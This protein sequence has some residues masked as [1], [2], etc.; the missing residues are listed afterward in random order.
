MRRSNSWPISIHGSA[1]SSTVN[2]TPSPE[3]PPRHLSPLSRKRANMK[4]EAKLFFFQADDGIR[5]ADVT[6]VQTC[7]LPICH[8][9]LD[10][11][12]LGR[13]S[14][15]AGAGRAAAGAILVGLGVP[16]GRAGDGADTGGRAEAA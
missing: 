11:Q 14:D 16:A 9:R 1:S 6:G 3:M 10:H 12:F 2:R 4:T 7:A 8:R 5:V 13:G 15:R